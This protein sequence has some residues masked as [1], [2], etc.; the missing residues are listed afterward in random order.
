MVQLVTRLSQDEALTSEHKADAR[1]IFEGRVDGRT[2]C[3]YCAG[4]HAHVAGLLMELQPCPRIK[5]IER[6]NNGT[7]AAVEYWP[8][9]EWEQDVIFPGDVYEDD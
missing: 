4:I 5:R 7:L 9:G 8:L 6:H 1:L 3:H 2:A